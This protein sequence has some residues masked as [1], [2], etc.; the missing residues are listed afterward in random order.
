M[1]IIDAILASYWSYVFF[2]VILLGASLIWVWNPFKKKRHNQILHY[3]VSGCCAFVFLFLVFS[4]AGPA[5]TFISMRSNGEQMALIDYHEVSD[6]DGGSDPSYRLY[7]IDMKTGKRIYRV[8]PGRYA[9]LLSVTKKGVIVMQGGV[10]YEYDLKEG[11]V[12]RQ[13]SKSGGFENYPELAS[14]IHQLSRGSYQFMNR[15]LSYLDITASNGHRY[16]LDLQTEQLSESRP[17]YKDT[18]TYRVSTTEIGYYQNYTNQ[19]SYRFKPL[20]GELKQLYYQKNQKEQ[21]VYERELLHPSIVYFQPQLKQLVVMHSTSLD[22]REII[23]TCLNSDL[24]PLWELTQRQMMPKDQKDKRRY[25]GPWLVHDEKLYMAFG[26]IVA[27][28]NMSNG[29]LIWT[30]QQ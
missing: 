9:E 25:P 18:S 11:N 22:A 5:V 13:W 19:S 24:V 26:G 10:V 8:R 20:N 6:A 27:C 30:V 29:K 4:A 16:Y 17:Q 28:V 1:E 23:L 21:I 14:G 12:T 7:L 15:E 3:S 2:G